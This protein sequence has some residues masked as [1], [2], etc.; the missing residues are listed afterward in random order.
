MRASLSDASLAR[1]AGRFVWLELDF[2]KPENQA[3][4]AEHHVTFTPTL[5]IIDAHSDR[6]TSTQLGGLTLPELR[7]FLDRGASDR[8]G[9]IAADAWR[10][11]NDKKWDAVAK[12]AVAEAPHMKGGEMRARVLLAGLWGANELKDERA[13]RVLEPLAAQAAVEDAILRD[14]RFQLYQQ[15]M[16]AADARGDKAALQKWGDRWLHEIDLT[17]PKD[18]DERSALDIARTDAADL[19]HQPHRV[20]PALAA[21]ERAMPSNYNASLRLAQMYLDARMYAESI[22]ACNR[23]LARTPGPKARDWLLRV[24]GDALK[25]L[26]RV[27]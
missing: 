5:F 24:R 19:L 14:H 27:Q 11:A 26:D 9:K 8:E 10:L 25:A 16:I 1:Y 23:G 4:I 20:I 15:L 22:A 12:L 18:D 13:L 21:S 3:F 6:A 7:A 2:D 17:V